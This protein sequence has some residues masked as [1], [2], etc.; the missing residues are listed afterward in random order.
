MSYFR[1]RR[2]GSVHVEMPAFS[3]VL[4]ADLARQLVEL[5]S[6]GEPTGSGGVDPLEELVVMDTPRDQPTD[7]A[8]LRLL[9]DAYPDDPEVAAEFR[10]F[11]EQ[12]LRKSK[13]EAALVV[14]G[15]L[16]GIEPDEVGS[17]DGESSVEFEL[18]ADD[19]RAWLRCLTDLR[20]TLAARLELT[21]DD[22][23]ATWL[24]L[25]EDDPR[26]SLYRIYGWLGYQ[27]ETLLDAA[28]R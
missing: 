10:R 28:Q 25:P 12:G 23:E 16:R 4:I 3:A 1:S 7:P 9:P 21:A 8:L 22:N 13:I 20:L 19:A 2:K 27:L 14:V 15:S 17:D 6:D 11:T 18:N 5:L 26:G 24:A